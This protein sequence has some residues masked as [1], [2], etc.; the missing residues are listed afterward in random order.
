LKI[1]HLANLKERGYQKTETNIAYIRKG[2]ERE[3]AKRNKDKERD[4][5]RK[6]ARFRYRIERERKRK[7]EMLK[8]RTL[9]MY[10]CRCMR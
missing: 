4:K 8:R 9:H 7:R 1:N 2:G 6:I 5:E 3:A 10:I